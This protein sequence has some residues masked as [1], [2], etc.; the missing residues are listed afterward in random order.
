[1]SKKPTLIIFGNCQARIIFEQFVDTPSLTDK[2]DIHFKYSFNHPTRNT[3]LTDDQIERCEI[4]W[5]QYTQNIT[6]EF[7][8]AFPDT[9]R[10]LVFP[11]ADTS[12]MWPTYALDPRNKKEPPDFPYGRYP[13]GDRIVVKLMNKGCTREEILDSYQEELEKVVGSFDRMQKMELQRYVARE[14]HCDVHIGKWIVNYVPK[15]RLFWSPNHPTRHVF[16]QMAKRLLMD[17]FKDES[18]YAPYYDEFLKKLGNNE[19]LSG[20]QVPIQPI[21]ADKLGL[22]WWDKDDTYLFRKT[23]KITADEYLRRYINW[24]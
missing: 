19:Y 17:T 12:M 2:Y 4:V 6:D 9:S 10:K 15:V 1:M 24:E 3:E 8:S 7:L 16:R 21:V 13:Y 22:E 5:A 18:V 14:R 23:E 11:S 20:D